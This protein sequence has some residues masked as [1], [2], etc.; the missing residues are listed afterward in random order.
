MSMYTHRGMAGGPPSSSVRL[1]ELLDQI[2][3][4]FDSQLR[5]SEGFEHQSKSPALQVGSS[6]GSADLQIAPQ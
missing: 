2:R 1:N 4:E 6:I 3:G 5:Q